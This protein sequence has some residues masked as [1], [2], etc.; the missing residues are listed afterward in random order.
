M[1]FFNYMDLR[2][3]FKNND[4]FWVLYIVLCMYDVCIGKE[5]NLIF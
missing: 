2:L 1:C 4:K 5:Y 3:I